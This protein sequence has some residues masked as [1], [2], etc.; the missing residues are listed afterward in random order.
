MGI[1]V[2][3]ED[4]RIVVSQPVPSGRWDFADEDEAVDLLAEKAHEDGE[5]VSFDP[6]CDRPSAYGRDGFSKTAFRE[7]LLDAVYELRAAAAPRM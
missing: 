3:I 4:G 6:S 5:S 7:R 1:N 2:G